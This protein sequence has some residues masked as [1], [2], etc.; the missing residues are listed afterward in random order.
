MSLFSFCSPLT[1]EPKT[2][3][4]LTSYRSSTGRIL[5]LSPWSSMP[6]IV[7]SLVLALLS[8][9]SAV[10]VGCNAAEAG[11]C[12]GVISFRLEHVIIPRLVSAQK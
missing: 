12:L 4:R 10:D 7:H 8:L 2:A 9:L 11:F 5:S 1:K 6:T 3:A